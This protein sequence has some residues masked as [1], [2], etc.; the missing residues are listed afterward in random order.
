MRK[1]IILMGV[2]VILLAFFSAARAEETYC[3]S[4]DVEF[5]PNLIFSKYDVDIFVNSQLLKT[6]SHGRDFSGMFYVQK[7]IYRIYFY[8][9]NEKNI[10]G[11]IN[12]DV[13][14]NAEVSC[15][16]S[17]YRDHVDVSNVSI[18]MEKPVELTSTPGPLKTEKP[19][20]T[21]TPVATS[22]PLSLSETDPISE[23]VPNRDLSS[24][25]NLVNLDDKTPTWTI[26]YNYL[27]DIGK[28]ISLRTKTGEE[29]VY[30]GH[31]LPAGNYHVR[32]NGNTPGQ[33]SFYKK[34]IVKDQGNDTLVPSGQKAILLFSGD[35]ASFKM[36]NGEFII[37]SD[38]SKDF[39]IES[40]NAP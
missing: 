17:C 7:G 4:L 20:A 13:K 39:Y 11:S 37:L 21:E 22:E 18:K 15:R 30:V 1:I 24:V 32:N 19:K 6:L 10:Y 9:H 26:S 27:S 28:K 8:K 38:G 14:G 25:M 29:M 16:I 23:P 35:E 2:L 3:V 31:F 5:V 12:V 34:G 36:K 33:I 40:V